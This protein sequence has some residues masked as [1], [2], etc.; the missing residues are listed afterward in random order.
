MPGELMESCAPTHRRARPWRRRWPL[1]KAPLCG[2]AMGLWGI[3]G[4]LS[5]GWGC[6]RRPRGRGGTESTT[7]RV[8]EETALFVL[9]NIPIADMA[10]LIPRL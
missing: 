4:G 5:C 1:I 7:G 6:P 9:P 3:Q 10:H 8:S 2:V